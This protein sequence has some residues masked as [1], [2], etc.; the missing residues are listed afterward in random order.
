MKSV[1]YIHWKNWCLRSNTLATW[2]EEL[3]HL[4]RPWARLKA[5]EQDDRGWDGWMASPAQWTWVWAN[6]QRWWKTGRPGVWQSMGLQ[7]RTQLTDWTTTLTWASLVLS[8]KESDSNAGNRLHCRRR[9][10]D[11]WVGKIPQR[12]AWQPTSVFLPGESHGQRSLAG[13]SSWSHKSW[14]WLSN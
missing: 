8:R 5:G 13:H 12:R 3:T 10:F 7:S 1:L 2:C 14:T 4:K 9:R 6:S 11:P